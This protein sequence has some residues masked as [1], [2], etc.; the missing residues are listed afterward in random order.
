MN[1]DIYIRIQENVDDKIECLQAILQIVQIQKEIEFNNE[2][3]SILFDDCLE[4][5]EKLIIN[6]EGLN[7]KFELLSFEAGQKAIEYFGNHRDNALYLKKRNEMLL[8]LEEEIRNL[9]KQCKLNF[10]CYLKKEHE[11]IKSFRLNNQV[12]SNYYKNMNNNHIT[13][14]YFMDNRK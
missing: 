4:K 6:I 2:Q 5:K 1:Q 10:E 14:S 12:A 7:R 3:D 11:K 13:E 8:L 9:E